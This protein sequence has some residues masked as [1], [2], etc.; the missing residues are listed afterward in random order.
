MKISLIASDESTAPLYR[1][2]LLARMLA[3]RFDVEVLGYHFDAAELDPDAPRDFPYRAVPARPLP[4]FL[5]DA[6]QLAGM[7]SGD[8]LYAMKPRPTSLGTALAIARCRGIPLLVDVDDLE[9]AMIPPFSRHALKN[10]AYALPRLNHPNNYLFTTACDRLTGLADAVTT[11]SR[12]F[13]QRVARTC[14]STPIFLVPQCVDTDRFDPDRFDRVA[15]RLK[16]GLDAFTV[17][18][19]GIA[20]PN[21]GV[22]EIVSALK[23]L[24]QRH[25]RLLIVGPKTP[26]ALELAACDPR[27]I[28]LGTQKPEDLPRYLA[29]ADAVVLP[30]RAEPASM[31]QMPMKLFEAMAMG[32]SVVS[33]RLADIPE[34]LD[35]CGKVVN[36]G[37]TPALTEAIADLMADPA[38][39]HHLGREARRKV[40]ARFSYDRGADVLEDL[41]GLV[42]GIRAADRRFRRGGPC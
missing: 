31:G 42:S 24:P 2:R 27:V 22:G 40:L 25:W 5:Q 28:L 19:A 35:G 34:V 3:R 16:L 18:F 6:R 12:F 41:I 33:T 29:V 26:Y 14:G 20:Q 36:P 17:V 32:C 38:H 4:A 7:V 1:V 13:Q 9:S 21:K 30:Q 37:D 10:A 8:V 11:V 23:R 39:A 15:L